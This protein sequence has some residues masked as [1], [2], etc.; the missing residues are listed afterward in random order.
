MDN[1]PVGI[2]DSGLGGLT[3]LNALRELLP[4]ENIIYFGDTGRV[5]Y[6][7][8]TREQVRRMAVQ[9]LDLVAAYGVKAMIVACGTISSNAPDIL[10]A[11]PIP[12]FGVLRA[13]VAGM[14]R[15]PGDG[16][17][18]VIATEASIRSGSFARALAD[19]CPGREI[20]PVACPDF[21]P[22]IE[23]GHSAP[24]DPLVLAAAAKYLAPLRGAAA[25]LLGC[26]HYG[27]IAEAITDFLGPQVQLISA[28]ECGAAALASLLLKRGQTG[29]SREA[30]FYTSGDPT[31]F[32]RAASLFCG[33]AV[34]MED[35][36]IVPAEPIPED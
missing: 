3:A 10:D 31:V 21:V 2:F 11:Y 14:S 13:G 4:E 18:G 27:L 33:A 35:V 9:D 16:P 19:A 15:I 17:L 32:S 8:K 36:Q 26:T 30:R 1:R 7:A 12:A 22:L 20:L 34:R 29:G 5:P 6:G 23:S 25:V 24:D 28:A